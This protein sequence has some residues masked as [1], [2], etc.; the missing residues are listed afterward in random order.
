M[1]LGKIT[2][3]QMENK[4][5]ILIIGASS[6][7]GL[8]VMKIYKKNDY[9]ILAH[10]NR[11][12]KKFFDYVK[13]NQI[14]TFKF[15]FLTSTTNLQKF[16]SK[17]IFKKSNIIINASGFIKQVPFLKTKIADIEKILKINRK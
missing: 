17:N 12:N 6:D 9:R 11:G 2:M 8:S 14:K 5:N 13:N 10:Y 15:N 7:I 4:K 1:K 3:P 16:F